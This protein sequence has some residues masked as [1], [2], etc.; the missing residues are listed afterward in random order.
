[1]VE[2]DIFGEYFGKGFLPI[3]LKEHIIEKVKYYLTH[4]EERKQIALNGYNKVKNMHR[5]CDRF[6]EMKKL[7][8][9]I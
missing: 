5:Y 1:M 4:E 2:A 8:P 9:E 7:I 3:M 6:D